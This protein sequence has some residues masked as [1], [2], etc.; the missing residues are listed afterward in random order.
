MFYFL[1]SIIEKQAA[2]LALA[3]AIIREQ[4]EQL[5][6]VDL[7]LESL[8]ADIA[9]IEGMLDGIAPLAGE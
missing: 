7:D 8:E 5:A 1:L 3:G 9:D 4:S 2:A 6:D